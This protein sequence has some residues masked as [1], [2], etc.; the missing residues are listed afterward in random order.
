MCAQ[1]LVVDAANGVGAPKLAEAAGRLSDLGLNIVVINSGTSGALNAGCGADFV[2]KEQ[3]RPAGF[4]SIPSGMRCVW[5]P[6]VSG[7]LTLPHRLILPW[8][9][10]A[11]F[12]DKYCRSV[13][14]CVRQNKTVSS[15]VQREA[16]APSVTAFCRSFA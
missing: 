8:A 12:H 6:A 9:L 16:P 4:E 2:Q 5:S 13:R 14:T 3:A 11:A 10:P 1:A 7:C 15:L